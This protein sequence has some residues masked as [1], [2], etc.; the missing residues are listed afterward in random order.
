MLMPRH[1]DITCLITT[2]CLDGPSYID[3]NKR[4]YYRA[5]YYY[6]Y[7]ASNGALI[8]MHDC[9]RTNGRLLRSV[10]GKHMQRKVC[11]ALTRN[12]L[13]SLLQQ[14]GDSRIKSIS[15]PR[16]YSSG[17][18]DV[19]DNMLRYLDARTDK[20]QKHVQGLVKLSCKVYNQVHDKRIES[21]RARSC[22][23]VLILRTESPRYRFPIA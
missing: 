2:S 18:V 7:V 21:D 16:K 13:I 9:G 3:H 22:K 6:G 19:K 12:I 15:A 11:K 4:P 1:G 20:S 14:Y 17:P 23:K 5:G 8:V 10:P